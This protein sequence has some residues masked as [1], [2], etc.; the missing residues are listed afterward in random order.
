MSAVEPLWRRALRSR[1][2]IVWKRRRLYLAAHVWINGRCTCPHVTS[3]VARVKPRDD[4]V[5]VPP[6]V[7][8][9]VDAISSNDLPYGHVCSICAQTVRAS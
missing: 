9:E 6:F 7:A 2:S 8:L 4:Q 1:V 5:E 3:P